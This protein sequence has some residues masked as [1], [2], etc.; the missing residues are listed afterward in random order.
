MIS[1]ETGNQRLIFR[2]WLGLAQK[3]PTRPETRQWSNRTHAAFRAEDLTHA[4][5]N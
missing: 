5:T 4:E 2:I 3:G 1:R